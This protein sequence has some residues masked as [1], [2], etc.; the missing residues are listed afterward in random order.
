MPTV[1]GDPTPIPL[2][3][4]VLPDARSGRMVDLGAEPPRAVLT[5]IRHR[6]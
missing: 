6:H 2:A 4:I 1:P 5:V 3:G